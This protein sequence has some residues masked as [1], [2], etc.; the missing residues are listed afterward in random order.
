ME[1]AWQW[2][3]RLPDG[4]IL[5]QAPLWC[6]LGGAGVPRAAGRMALDVFAAAPPEHYCAA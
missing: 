4:T 3:D 6:L 1:R 5:D 2:F